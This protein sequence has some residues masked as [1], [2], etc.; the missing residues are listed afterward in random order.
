MNF[1]QRI[2]KKAMQNVGDI[3]PFAIT[4][5][6]TGIALAYFLLV[7]AD[8]QTDIE[9]ET[10]AN[11]SAANASSEVVESVENITSK[12]PTLTTIGIA[13]LIIGL[14]VGGFLFLMNRRQ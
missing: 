2:K 10:S 4:I 8:V 9:A 14:L 6:V 7:H 5:G 13:V 3:L 12:M 1:L 11:S